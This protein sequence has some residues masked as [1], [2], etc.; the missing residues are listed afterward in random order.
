MSALTQE[1][2]KFVSFKLNDEYYAIDV[3]M[4]NEVFTPS[5]VTVIPQSEDFVAGVINYRGEI[6]SVIDLKIRL[7][8]EE[9]KK[10]ESDYDTLLDDDEDRIY[11]IIVKSG[12]SI[13]GLL[14][15][16]VEAVISISGNK[17]KST[18]DLISGKEKTTFLEGVAETEYG[19]TVLLALDILLSDYDIKDS[20]ALQQL[21]DKIMKEKAES[22]EVVIESASIVD[23]EKDDIDQ[24]EEKTA[25]EPKFKKIT[26][27]SI[28]TGSDFGGSPLDLNSLTKSELI[29]IAIEMNIS[30]VTTK[31]TK[32]EIIDKINT[33][34]GN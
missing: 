28:S 21:R 30:N 19:L 20:K 4:V 22:E 3:K 9:K 26:E 8:I 10:V 13:V 25:S 33:Q 2:R 32:Q 31:S 12:A 5:S 18:L 34:L 24:Y 14:V 11:V 27:K 15:D 17:I 23:L 16:Y 6:V 7:Q 1:E 29:K